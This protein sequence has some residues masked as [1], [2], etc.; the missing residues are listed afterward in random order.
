MIYAF[1]QYKRGDLRMNE[2]NN[3]KQ[4]G[5]QKADKQEKRMKLLTVTD[6]CIMLL[7]VIVLAAMGSCLFCIVSVNNDIDVMKKTMITRKDLDDF[8]SISD[9]QFAS[10]NQQLDDLYDVVNNLKDNK[11]GIE[12]AYIV[13]GDNVATKTLINGVSS[14]IHTDTLKDDTALWD[15]DT[16]LF[17]EKDGQKSLAKEVS[18]NKLLFSYTD[19]DDGSVVYFYGQFSKDNKWDGNCLI[20]V[21]KNNKLRL[22]TDA[23]YD[24]GTLTSYKQVLSSSNAAG[25]GVWLISK[26]DCNHN[27]NS[28]DTWSYYSDKDILQNFTQDSFNA[29]DFLNVSNFKNNLN[30]DLEGFYHGDTSKGS[31]NDNSGKAYLIKFAKDGTVRMF[32]MGGFV[33]GNLVD[34]TGNAWEI[35]RNENAL[36]SKY[37]LKEG[38]FVDGDLDRAREHVEDYG[39]TEDVIKEKMRNIFVVPVIRWYGFGKV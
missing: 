19:A 29:S 9:R 31:Y 33:N 32:Y 15:S 6:C 18:G 12:S 26:R 28:G 14:I 8:K 5:Q 34:N 20:N 38:Y 22:I 21:Y 36:D 2:E 7:V 39:I 24:N 25:R 1:A 27:I 4:R 23:I 37:V 3:D 10:T 17:K 11:Q 30:T 13:T 35:A 16:I